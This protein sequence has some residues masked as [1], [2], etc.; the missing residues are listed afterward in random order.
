MIFLMTP[1]ILYSYFRS[2]AAYRVRIAM[3]LKK[4]PFEYRA[5]HLLSN[6]GA[7][8]QKGYRELNPM[9]EVPLVVDGA[10]RIGQS[11]AILQYLD[12]KW[13]KPLLFPKDIYKRAEV[14]QFCENINSGIHPVQNLKLLQEL[15]KRFKVDQ[16]GKED[17]AKHWIKKRL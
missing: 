5:V 6:G 1:I 14:I 8:N 10:H 12:E 4:V 11:M 13:P 9:G 16:T 3:L 2:S 7:Q 15:E 17:W